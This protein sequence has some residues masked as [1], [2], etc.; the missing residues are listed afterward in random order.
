[1]NAMRIQLVSKSK[2]E[3]LLEKYFDAFEFDFDYE[4]S[5]L[6]SPP[7]RRTAFVG[8]GGAVLTEHEMVARLRSVLEEGKNGGGRSNC[9]YGWGCISSLFS[10]FQKRVKR[11]REISYGM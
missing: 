1:M 6:W 8:E 10:V 3:K 2:S 9:F 11:R 5:G 7:V 4:Q